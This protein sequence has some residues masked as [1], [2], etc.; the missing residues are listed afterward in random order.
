MGSMATVFEIAPATDAQ[1]RAW[2]NQRWLLLLAGFAL[3]GAIGAAYAIVIQTKGDW[4]HGQAWE[5]A[6]MMRI[7]QPLPRVI[8]S[9]MLVFPWFGTNISLIPAIAVMV[10]W[11][12]AKR[13]QPH[14]A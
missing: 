4:S 10:W 2:W 7:H 12:W 9:L 8:D 14:L 1:P 13:G 6:L 3:A 5:R 11:L